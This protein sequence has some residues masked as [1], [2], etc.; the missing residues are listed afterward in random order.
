MSDSENSYQEP[1]SPDE[2]ARASPAARRWFDLGRLR[3]D[4]ILALGFL[5]RLPRGG[6]FRA[7]VVGQ[8]ASLAE[9]SLAFPF[10]GLVVG[11]IGAAVYTGALFIHLTPLLAALL[12]MAATALA[13][14]ALHEDGLSDF[15]DALG[16]RGGRAARLAI[17]RDSR[18]GVF[19]AL[20]LVFVTMI[21]AAALVALDA[22]GRAAG[23][24]LAAH[25]L[26]RAILPFIMHSLPNARMDGL[27]A[28]AG[29]PN[30]EAAYAA[31]GVGL[32]L[33]V[34]VAGFSGALVAGVAALAAA[35]L[36]SRLAQRKI[37][38]WTGDVLGAAEQ[39]AEVAVL[40]NLVT[41]R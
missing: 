17:M 2:A 20:A 12:A 5:T 40:V 34:L 39:V 33:A 14:G 13:T 10:V 24:L 21:K 29:N 4:F 28:W 37:G 27:G 32:L 3:A 41:L 36:V 7:S 16:V 31:L 23:G 15:T 6:L 9:A 35:F 30:R 22:S 1:T 38:G 11:A 26:S 25:V 18:I 8:S 19:G